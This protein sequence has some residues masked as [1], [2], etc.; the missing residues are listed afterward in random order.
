MSQ[1]TIH[2]P[3]HRDIVADFIADP[4]GRALALIRID[5]SGAFR[6]CVRQGPGLRCS[7]DEAVA[8]D[9]YLVGLYSPAAADNLVDALES[10]ACT[11]R[12]AVLE[13]WEDRARVSGG[14]RRRHEA[15]R[16]VA[17]VCRWRARR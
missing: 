11:A 8:D 15:G 13:V 14:R 12:R 5:E 16:A 6:F 2:V 17:P 7:H 1:T 10:L 4:D 3:D 9:V